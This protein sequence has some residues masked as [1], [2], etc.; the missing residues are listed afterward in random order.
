MRNLFI[1]VMPLAVLTACGTKI[2]TLR[3]GAL[4]VGTE[5]ILPEECP[6]LTKGP[7]GV[8]ARA[9]VKASLSATDREVMEQRS[10]ETLQKLDDREQLSLQDIKNMTSNGLNDKTIIAQINAT[11]STFCL[12]PEEM[13][14]LSQCG[15]SEK[16]INYMIK[17]G[18]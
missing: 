16:V 1:F 4:G 14:D 6:P 2:G 12:T 13:E 5:D 18:E 3:G 10:P 11:R 7:I 9:Q 8:A 15:V 17:T